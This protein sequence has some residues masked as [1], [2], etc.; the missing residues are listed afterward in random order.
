MTLV[1][2]NVSTKEYNVAEIKEREKLLEN[3]QVQMP[4]VV[5]TLKKRIYFPHLAKI[6]QEIPSKPEDDR[7]KEEGEGKR[8]TM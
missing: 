7:K 6:C 3:C 1:A 8:K 2:D 5:S 4:C